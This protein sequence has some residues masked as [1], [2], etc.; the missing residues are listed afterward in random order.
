MGASDGGAVSDGRWRRTGGVS[1]RP[2]W[3]PQSA[4]FLADPPSRAMPAMLRLLLRG[5]SPLQIL[6][7]G[8]RMWPAISDGARLVVT[9]LAGT[10]PTGPGDPPPGLGAPPPGPGDIV[11]ACPGG[12]PDL[13]RIVDVSGEVIRLAADAD[14]SPPVHVRREDL[15]GVTHLPESRS[16]RGGGWRAGRRLVLDLREAVAGRP[17]PAPDPAQTVRSKYDAQA[18]FYAGVEGPGL[19][20]A[21]LSW[22][23]ERVPRE[24]R[25]FVA[26]SGTGR[27]CFALAGEG[28]S[29]SGVDFSSAMIDLARKEAVRLGVPVTFTAAD[30]RAHTEPP[31]SI[32]AVFFTFDVYSF[33]PHAS[34]RIDLLAHMAR[35]LA[36]G[37]VVFLSARR[38]VHPY[39]R[40]ILT[41]QKL[42][43]A[44]RGGAWGGSH[45]RWIDA[46]ARV[47]RSFVQVF[48]TDAI[49][50]E[51]HAAG[52]TMGP[53][54]GNHCLLEPR[55]LRQTAP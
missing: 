32:A 55:P 51:A 40:A 44:G 5:G 22:V 28:W 38:C 4:V 26:G 17:D 48:T 10:A 3:T 18:P 29:V 47:R 49:R 6:Y 52:Y 35:W 8:D 7:A 9:P 19:S 30:L 37:G 2:F 25:I 33:L 21:L 15:L 36:P 54:R 23:R 16:R 50:R 41:L 13:L 24:G 20:D 42:A 34:E 45:T 14:A 12:I 31:G 53:W 46:D 43:R 39:D 11:L 27:E 1:V